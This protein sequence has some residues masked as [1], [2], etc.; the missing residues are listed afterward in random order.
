MRVN[1]TCA[2]SSFTRTSCCAP[3]SNRRAEG[4]RGCR[5]A[6]CLW[7]KHK[8]KRFPLPQEAGPLQVLL[9]PASGPAQ[10]SLGGGTAFARPPLTRHTIQ[11]VPLPAT[12]EATQS[13]TL[14]HKRSKR[15]FPRR[16]K[17]ENLVCAEGA[18]DPDGSQ[19]EEAGADGADAADTLSPLQTGAAQQHHRGM[20]AHART[21]A[22]TTRSASDGLGSLQ[23]HSLLFSSLFELEEW[24]AAI[25]KLTTDG[26]SAGQLGA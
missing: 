25:H 3:G 14:T 23:T 8:C 12:A 6:R 7:W 26:R 2:T 16:G 19:Q 11:D 1:A 13:S 4:E 17:A 9:V 15:V 5:A 20:Y 24:R 22:H 21:H 10:A 18:Q